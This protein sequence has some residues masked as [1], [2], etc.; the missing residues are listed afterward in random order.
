MSRQSGE[1]LPLQC[2]LTNFFLNLFLTFGEHFDRP[3]KD[4]VL[5]PAG[6]CLGSL[7]PEIDN[8]IKINRD[9][10]KRQSFNNRRQA[11]RPYSDVRQGN[12]F[13]ILYMFTIHWRF[14]VEK[15]LLD[16]KFV[17]T[18]RSAN[19]SAW[20]RSFSYRGPSRRGIN[21]PGRPPHRMLGGAYHH[22]SA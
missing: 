17:Y 7:V 12:S 6:N 9:N 13:R 1:Y 16:R 11:F 14:L 21:S 3:A 15:R 18:L 20:Q 19:A 8:P 10:P 5:P 22:R 4:F 2:P